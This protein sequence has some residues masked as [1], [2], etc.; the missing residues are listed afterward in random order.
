[1]AS[2]F[3]LTN[4]CGEVPSFF[5]SLQNLLQLAVDDGIFA[6]P[7]P[8]PQRASSA[9]PVSKSSPEKR[10]EH[11]RE[12]VDAVTPPPNAIPN[13]SS[14]T[15][16][17]PVL[18][19][20]PKDE[21]VTRRVGGVAP[22][23]PYTPLAI[24]GKRRP[25]SAIIRSAAPVPVAP[26]PDITH[27][28][29]ADCGAGGDKEN[30]RSEYVD[31]WLEK[32]YFRNPVVVTQKAGTPVRTGPPPSVEVV[33]IADV[34]EDEEILAQL[35][36][37]PSNHNALRIRH[38]ILK[39]KLAQVFNVTTVTPSQPQQQQQRASSRPQSPNVSRLPPTTTVADSVAL[40]SASKFVER[41]KNLLSA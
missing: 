13:S 4:D 35:P 15:R 20:V 12:H 11:K 27:A 33:H 2:I 17:V 32:L 25:N 9:P 41:K 10:T 40:P 3:F 26:Q 14:S 28:P 22:P 39:E 23:S 29:S 21:A 18:Q 31:R 30:R 24:G 7:V 1:M 19:D 37:K 36:P 6:L 34:R 16:G 38:D 8:P 5:P